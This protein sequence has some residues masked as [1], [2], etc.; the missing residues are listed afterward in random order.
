MP[1]HGDKLGQLRDGQKELQM[2]LKEERCAVNGQE[3]QE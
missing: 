2:R 1:G 3:D